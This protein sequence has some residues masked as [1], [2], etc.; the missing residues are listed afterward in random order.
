MQ[1]RLPSSEL[2]LFVARNP[3]GSRLQLT[4]K[5]LGQMH[6]QHIVPYEV[7]QLMNDESEMALDTCLSSYDFPNTGTAQVLI[8][9]PERLYVEPMREKDTPPPVPTLDDIILA[10]VNRNDAVRA[11]QVIHY[12]GSGCARSQGKGAG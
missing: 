8:Q 7:F 10:F 11:L 6:R 1:V 5:Y 4:R 3:D 2:K 9:R 12:S